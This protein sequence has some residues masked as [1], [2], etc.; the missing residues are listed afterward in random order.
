MLNGNLEV[1]FESVDS[2]MLFRPISVAGKR[3]GTRED[4]GNL[5]T[6]ESNFAD[7]NNDRLQTS[8]P[9]NCLLWLRIAEYSVFS[10]IFAA[11]SFMTSELQRCVRQ[12]R[13]ERVTIK[14]K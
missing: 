7:R 6:L 12:M 14:P 3:T 1:L 4:L 11:S 5:E 13:E 10:N 8:N 9:I 2:S